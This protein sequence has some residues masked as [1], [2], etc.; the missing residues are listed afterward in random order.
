VRILPNCVD[1]GNIKL[2]EPS[3]TTTVVFVGN[4]NY[5]PNR[6]GATH[7]MHTLAP[8]IPEA[9][10]LLVGSGLS[11]QEPP[12]GNV[13]IM[14]HVKDVRS[15]MERATVCIAPVTKGSGTRLKIL[16]YLAFGRPVV[17]TTKACE[18][19][20]AEDGIHLI[21]R[22][23]WREFGTAI[24]TLLDD[25]GLRSQ[26]GA[27]GRRL[28]ETKFDWR[29]YVDW[30]RNFMGEVMRAGNLPTRSGDR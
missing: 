6:D 28:V 23:T 22:D 14:G 24:R 21:I 11:A 12:Q 17:A 10:F 2:T 26:L 5:V 18:G 19:L 3:D 9:T 30:M 29:V 27:G 7:V 4:F 15:V 16:T 8:M 13:K 1:A 20:G 25:P